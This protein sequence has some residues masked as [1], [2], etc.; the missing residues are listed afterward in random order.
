MHATPKLKYTCAAAGGRDNAAWGTAVTQRSR[1][2]PRLF[3][4]TLQ[5]FERHLNKQNVVP[6]LLNVDSPVSWT[7]RVQSQMI[8]HRLRE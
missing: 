5:R 2:D 3:I 6:V 4:E 1:S 7:E 8:T